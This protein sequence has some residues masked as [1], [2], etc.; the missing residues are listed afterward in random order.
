MF[1]VNGFLIFRKKVDRKSKNFVVLK[2][3][4]NSNNLMQN[5]YYCFR[6]YSSYV[7]INTVDEA[8]QYCLSKY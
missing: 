1:N 5:E 3:L 7:L 6:I 8:R 4:V 2:I